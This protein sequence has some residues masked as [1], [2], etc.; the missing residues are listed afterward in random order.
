MCADYEV[1]AGG[2]RQLSETDDAVLDLTWKQVAAIRQLQSPVSVD[3]AH[4]VEIALHQVVTRPL[5]LLH[6]GVNVGVE[7]PARALAPFEI[8]ILPALAIA[9]GMRRDVPKVIETVAL[10]LLGAARPDAVESLSF[11]HSADG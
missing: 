1:Y 11:R 5:Y 4:G 2:S 8:R 6:V 10:L 3:G 9:N 7:Q